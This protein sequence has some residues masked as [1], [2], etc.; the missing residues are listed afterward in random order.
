MNA[1]EIKDL[2]FS[3]SPSD[4]TVIDIPAWTVK[5]GEQ[6]FIVGPS[7]SGKSTLLNLLCG[8]L[9][10]Q[11]GVI[12]LLQQSFSAL[13]SRQRDRFRAK[14]IGVV[15]QQF[16]LIPY[17]TVEQN[18]QLAAYFGDNHI[19]ENHDTL[20]AYFSLLNLPESLLEKP[21]A[22]LSV[23]QQ[24]RVAIARALINKP[25]ILIVDEPTSALDKHARDGFMQL[26]LDCINGSNSTL[27]F[28]SHDE[29]LAAHF[30]RTVH[31]KSLQQ[32]GT[33]AC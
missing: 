13:P 6:V 32:T 19:Q 21:A 33:I 1:I 28:V 26:L 8:T 23:G 12:E 31:I 3:Y 27:L 20:A 17:M 16:N 15:F 5:Q 14:H 22:T 11:K 18:I 30:N 7:G 24:Q 10:P 2:Q 29:T 25:E 4:A 9:S